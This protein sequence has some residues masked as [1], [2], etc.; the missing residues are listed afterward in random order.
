MMA[1][2]SA[3]MARRAATHRAVFL[4]SMQNRIASPELDNYAR[5]RMDPFYGA[6][7]I[8]DDPY[9]PDARFELD[10]DAP[11]A[12]CPL[13]SAHRTPRPCSLANGHDGTCRFGPARAV[14]ATPAA[15]TVAIAP[16]SGRPACPRCGQ[17]FR[18]GGSG[19]AWHVANRPDCA[20]IA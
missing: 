4:G 17:T 5:A 13:R 14:V 6:A 18:A 10:T 7:I 12:D 3:A 11:P 20:P 8:M 2:A 1:I 15:P 16:S 9:A 19:Y